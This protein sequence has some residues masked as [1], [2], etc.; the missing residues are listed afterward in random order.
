MGLWVKVLVL[1][2]LALESEARTIICKANQSNQVHHLCSRDVLVCNEGLFGWWN[3]IKIDFCNGYLVQADRKLVLDKRNLWTL[4]CWYWGCK[5]EFT[6]KREPSE[7]KYGHF[8]YNGKCFREALVDDPL[9]QER[10]EDNSLVR[11]KREF[12]NLDVLDLPHPQNHITGNYFYQV[13]QYLNGTNTIVCYP[14][15]IGVGSL[16]SVYPLGDWEQLPLNCATASKTPPETERIKLQYDPNLAPPAD[17]YYPPLKKEGEQ[18]MGGSWW[19]ENLWWER[20]VPGSH[21]P[22]NNRGYENCFAGHG[23]GCSKIYICEENPC[24]HKACRHRHCA[25]QDKEHGVTCICIDSRCIPLVKGEQLVCGH[26]N[27]THLR[28]HGQTF[29]LT[30]LD[31]HGRRLVNCSN[32]VA[33]SGY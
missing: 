4:P 8:L 15:P 25:Y 11:Q 20:R 24:L 2:A 31:D 9:L 21:P 7:G 33:V 18:E 32:R 13:H 30:R 29:N 27:G 14:N 28:A 10:E 17:C 5:F 22:R 1:V 19:K 12:P 6:C 23:W 26:M 3:V 16:F